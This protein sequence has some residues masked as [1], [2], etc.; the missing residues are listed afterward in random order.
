MTLSI[1]SQRLEGLGALGLLCEQFKGRLCCRSQFS[2]CSLSEEPIARRQGRA[3]EEL[4]AD[5]EKLFLSYSTEKAWG[6][7]GGEKEGQGWGSGSNRAS[8]LWG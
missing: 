3:S 2:L 4:V 8:M 6:G 1:R 5:L 7:E